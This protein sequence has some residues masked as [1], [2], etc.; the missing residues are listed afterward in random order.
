MGHAPEQAHLD[1]LLFWMFYLSYVGE[2]LR[3][4]FIR[5]SISFPG[6]FLIC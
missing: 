6:A 1:I 5:I 3:G 2:N 4:G